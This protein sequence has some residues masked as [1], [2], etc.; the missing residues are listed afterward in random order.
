MRSKNNFVLIIFILIISISSLSFAETISSEEILANPSKTYD[1]LSYLSSQYF[2]LGNFDKA[3]SYAN[4]ALS[5]EKEELGPYQS[6]A[7][8]YFYKKDFE[9]AI[10]SF[11]KLS[12][13][14]QNKIEEFLREDLEKL[15]N[16]IN[17]TDTELRVAEIIMIF[18]AYPVLINL[19]VATTQKDKAQEVVN[20]YVKLMKKID[21]KI[22]SS[23]YKLFN[24]IKIAIDAELLEADSDKLKRI[25]IEAD[26][27]QLKN[28][29]GSASLENI[30]QRQIDANESIVLSTLAEVTVACSIFFA[31]N[32]TCP[33]SLSH[34]CQIKVPETGK[35]YL[36]NKRVC[37]TSGTPK[38]D[39]YELDY[40]LDGERSFRII[41]KP[42]IPDKTGRRYFIDNGITLVED[43][44]KNGEVDMG[45]PSITH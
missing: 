15:E 35:Y 10:S 7:M 9:G 19:Y 17:E 12:E 16:P 43:M 8:A 28:N 20:T 22:R 30:L 21:E 41:A 4:E 33:E 45:E 2:A 23:R 27:N 11:E 3:I 18:N 14:L 37:V 13:M 26:P 42:I 40:I 39:G 29:I 38:I 32:L 36:N 25:I 24:D 5:L 31:H 44:N 34:L 6:K 1:D